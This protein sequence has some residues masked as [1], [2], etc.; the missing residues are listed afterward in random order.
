VIYAQP[1]P[2]RSA[3]NCQCQIGK[4]GTSIGQHWA[5]RGIG[6]DEFAA[7]IA[8]GVILPG[9]VLLAFRVAGVLAHV[10]ANKKLFAYSQSTN[11]GV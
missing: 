9:L 7:G 6:S 11:A 3:I 2:G 10:L 4:D 5:F 1:R 8:M